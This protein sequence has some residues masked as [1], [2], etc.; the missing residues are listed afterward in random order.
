MVTR[1][2]RIGA[3]ALATSAAVL[4]PGTWMP[5]LAEPGRAPLRV[6]VVSF[7]TDLVEP[8]WEFD[9][10]ATELGPLA[11]SLLANQLTAGTTFT[12]VE[13]QLL[14][15]ILREQDFGASGRF[16]ES[17]TAE[18]GRLVGAQFV[19]IG[20]VSQFSKKNVALGG[21]V[22]KLKALG[23]GGV[24]TIVVGLQARLVDAATATVVAAAEAKDNVKNFAVGAITESAAGAGG[25]GTVEGAVSKALEG[26]IQK[27]ALALDQAVVAKNIQPTRITM[28]LETTVA[29]VSDG[30]AYLQGGR[31]TGIGI[32]DF[33]EIKRRGK[34]I[35][36][37]AGE[38]LDHV[39]H[40]IGVLEV[41]EVRDRLSLARVSTPG[42]APLEGDVARR[43][44]PPEMAGSA[45]VPPKNTA[46]AESGAAPRDAAG[47]AAPAAVPA[48]AG[49]RA[50]ADPTG[51]WRLDPRQT[52]ITSCRRLSQAFGFGLVVA[53]GDD[54]AEAIDER[55]KDDDNYDEMLR[56]LE[57]LEQ[58][59]YVKGD[60]TFEIEY[61]DP[62]DG[63][64]TVVSGPWTHDG[65]SITLEGR[66]R[67]GREMESAPR[68][69]FKISR[70]TLYGQWDAGHRQK[71]P[72]SEQNEEAMPGNPLGLLG[73]TWPDFTGAVFVRTEA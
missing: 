7:N 62:V 43:V 29:A 71:A 22:P 31:D 6:A 4:I 39:E 58:T 13:R 14:E 41:Y 45:C 38:V 69:P 42:A 12:V 70:G 48:A 54:C 10:Q 66:S 16:D 72:R 67:D 15:E 60:G 30:T 52:L 53:T 28:C 64:V 21:F 8:K 44:P 65:A 23:G 55:D 40:A 57:R 63:T 27:L 17:T 2:F 11:A 19:V 51:A 32:G 25:G 56:G 3:L 36:N 37:S 61:V 9:F 50:P 24:S 35:T 46:Q 47:S 18:I 59:L 73:V 33:F 68:F 1:M 49:V 34:A 5:T 26:G 20:D